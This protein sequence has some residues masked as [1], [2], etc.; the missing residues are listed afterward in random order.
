MSCRTTDDDDD[1]DGFKSMIILL[2]R[3]LIGPLSTK[4]TSTVTFQ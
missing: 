4:I 1:N 2:R 3:Q